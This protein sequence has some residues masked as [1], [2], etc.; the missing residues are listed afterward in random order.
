MGA[1]QFTDRRVTHATSNQVAGARDPPDRADD[2]R[3]GG[4]FMQQHCHEDGRAQGGD[5]HDHKSVA[6][7]KPAQK[8]NDRACVYGDDNINVNNHGFGPGLRLD[9]VELA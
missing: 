9:H 1:E 6:S 8:Q 5:P 4:E 7:E 2:R 3:R